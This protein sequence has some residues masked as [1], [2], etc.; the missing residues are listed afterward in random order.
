MNQTVAIENVKIGMYLVRIEQS[1][2]K[3]QVKS[4]GLIKS[5][6]TIES[7]RKRGVLSIVIDVE[8][9]VHALEDKQLDDAVDIASKT[10]SPSSTQKK[11]FQMLSFEQQQED[12]A[13]ADRL[14][15]QA[16]GVQTR[17]V[18]ELRSGGSPDFD[19]LNE[20]CQDI[21]D[22]VF[23]NYEALSCLV[24]LKDTN[25][26][27][28]EHSLNCAIL[29]SLFAKHEN[30]SQSDIEDMTLSGLLMD[31]GMALLPNELSEG[32]KA[33]SANDKALM[34]SHVDIGFEVIERYTDLPPMVGDVI[35][36][37]H[38]RIDGSGYPKQKTGEQLS[39]YVQIAS[40]VDTYDA[41]ISD[42]GYRSAKCS[43]DA[44]EA[45]LVDPGFDQHLVESFIEAIGLYPVGSLVHLKS[46]KLGIVVQKH[47]Q[48]PFKPKVMTFYSIRN[49]HHTEVKLVDLLKSNDKIMGAVRPQ[50][51]DINLPKFFKTVLL[52]P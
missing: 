45:M 19:K 18:K 51:F 30:Y 42:R 34:Q 16:R 7:L 40:I 20:I 12:L 14:Y 37:H 9:S 29:M 32:N 50:E 46:G 26:Y 22:S 11:P 5:S 43:Q 36:N 27:L 17:F 52:K 31:I 13:K 21:I 39:S 38:E 6:A 8:K 24:M 2:K 4:Q 28:V 15:T 33:Y 23:E 10:I 25:D 35:L 47:K 1:E 41:M 48:H 49:K 44:L 3:L